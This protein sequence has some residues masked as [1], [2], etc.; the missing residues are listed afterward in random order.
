MT[1]LLARPRRLRSLL[2][3]LTRARGALALSAMLA[4]AVASGCGAEGSP[5]SVGQQRLDEKSMESLLT[6]EDLEEA[7][8]DTS[9]L[10]VEVEDVLLVAG[11]IE[12]DQLEGV[13]SWHAM[14]VKRGKTGAV[15]IFTV[16]EMTT[17][18]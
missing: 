6:L 8:A 18:E 14:K 9:R 12:A 7:G 3:A 2:P 11:A 15:L 4:G 17:P 13:R 5:T 10:S 1:R 16:I